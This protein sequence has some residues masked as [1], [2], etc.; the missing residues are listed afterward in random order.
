MKL[1]VDFENRECV[2]DIHRN[3]SGCAYTLT[4]ALNAE[5][6]CTI[7]EVSPGVFSVLNGMSSFVVRLLPVE[8]GL[9]AWIGRKRF[10]LSVSDPRDK[11]PGGSDVVAQGPK[12]IRSLMPGKVIKLLVQT[13]AQVK[14]GDGV[15]IVEAMKMQNEMKSP[16]D[17]TIKFIHVNEGAT[18]AA[19]TP[20]LTVE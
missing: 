3:A 9:E 15:I 1:R 18:V 13:G 20:L 5:D 12:E 10:L 11:A 8:G 2:L 4:G 14:A 17:G 7:E 16:K 6:C 19:G